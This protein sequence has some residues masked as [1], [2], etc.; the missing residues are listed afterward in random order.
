MSIF[1]GIGQFTTTGSLPGMAQFGNGISTYPNPTQ[2]IVNIE[3]NSDEEEAITF[4]VL[5]VSGRCVQTTK[6]QA[7]LGSNNI[8]ISLGSLANGLYIIK[9]LQGDNVRTLGKVTKQ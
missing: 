4:Y 9:S 5:D 6:A 7:L 3:F 1:S 2:D 8:Q